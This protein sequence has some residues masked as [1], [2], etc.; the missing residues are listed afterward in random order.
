M[1]K[2]NREELPLNRPQLLAE[3]VNA[4]TEIDIWGRG[5]GKTHRYGR[6]TERLIHEMPGGV[7]L[8]VGR[9][10][11]QLQTIVVPEIIYAW[12]QLRYYEGIHYV[13]GQKPPKSVRFK[14]PLRPPVKREHFIHWYNGAGIHL[15]SQDREGAG[16]GYNAS[17]VM[18]DEGLTLNEERFR[19]EVLAANR[20]DESQGWKSKLVHSVT[21]A[22]SMPAGSE[23]EWLLRYGDYYLEQGMNYASIQKRIANMQLSFVRL[24]IDGAPREEALELWNKIVL[25]KKKIK[26]Y[27]NTQRGALNNVFYNE[28]NAFDNIGHLGINYLIRQYRDLT[29]LEFMVEILNLKVKDVEDGFYPAF[30]ENR[31]C[32][33]DTYNYSYLDTIGWDQSK[34]KEKD[35]RQ[36]GDIDPAR[37]IDIACDYGYHLNCMVVGQELRTKKGWF[38]LF[39]N[40]IWRKPP[41]DISDVAKEFCRYYRHH[42]CKIVNFYYDH[43]SIDKAGKQFSYSEQVI[44]VLEA[45][46]WSV[47]SIYIGQQ[48]GHD[49]RYHLMNQAFRADDRIP[50]PLFSMPNCKYLVLSIRL[51]G[52]VQG[53][54]GFE[55]DK[56]PEKNQSI[57][58][59]ETT[60]QTDAMDTLYYAK[61]IAMLRRDSQFVDNII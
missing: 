1:K 37:P 29:E 18:A 17:W 9:T 59:E 54:N 5:T 61:Y 49:A 32:Y 3:L 57:A 40:S 46:G 43:T 26:W 12:R 50:V 14:D 58:Q 52:V 48:P 22:S 15:I 24:L 11:G 55:K 44:R 51:S 36:D 42:V 53:K 21:I 23:G 2:S 35:C 25:E 39:L 13:I 20:G 45:S 30:S 60:H 16:R 19:K 31:H 33:Y 4:E 34:V 41:H 8:L 27:K 6:R 47:N 7:G 10:F 28:A 38:Y 56:R